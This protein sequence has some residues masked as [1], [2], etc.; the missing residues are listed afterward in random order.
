MTLVPQRHT[1]D[2]KFAATGNATNTH[3]PCLFS[4]RRAT[5]RQLLRL[6]LMVVV[7]LGCGTNM[8]PARGETEG[9]LPSIDA[10]AQTRG[11]V[12]DNASIVIVSNLADGGQG[13]LRHAIEMVGARIVVFEVAGVIW[14]K[15]DLT[16]SSPFIT[17][18]GQTAP[19]PGITLRGGK[20]LVKTHNVV[21]QHIAVRP[22]ASIY[23][24]VNRNRDAIAIYGCTD[25]REPAQ[26]VRLENV[27]ASWATDEV[28]GT[29][30][31]T[32]T[33][34][35]VRNSIISEALNEAGHPKGA[36]SMGLLIGQY[37][38]SVAVAGNLFASNMRRNPVISKGASA[39]V[40]NNFIYNPGR[41]AI[42]FYRGPLIRASVI[43]NVVKRGPSSKKKLVA[44]DVPKSLREKSA[45]SLIYARGN[46]CCTGQKSGSVLDA[47]DLNL[48]SYA[49]ARTSAWKTL[50]ADA[51]WNWV[52]RYAGKRPN[53]RDLIDKR[54]INDVETG[55]G[56]IINH[57]EDS[58]GPLVL[59][60]NTHRLELPSEPLAIVDDSGGLR[61]IEVWLCAKHL[62]VGGP[63]TPECPKVLDLDQD[64]QSQ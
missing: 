3:Q 39:I 52:R 44:L 24:E 5:N 20:L 48:L 30:G 40:V 15:S 51:V 58:A 6:L 9:R 62:E 60:T 37:V 14:L 56:R 10:G 35:T 7:L 4:S 43:G 61:R 27:S 32:L 17:V 57:Q 54:I 8:A 23:P 38:Q 29:W 26:D 49:P 64:K 2:R 45:G 19:S 63:P 33:R 36:H 47:P 18:A 12:A 50:P 16:I 1:I 28:I 34:V 46:L 42:H 55:S 13:S 11:G 53:D 41:E 31:K 25:C 59:T 22:G 21:I